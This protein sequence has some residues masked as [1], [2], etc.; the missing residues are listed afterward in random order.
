[1]HKYV[2][3]AIKQPETSHHYWYIVAT[4]ED[5]REHSLGRVIL[6]ERGAKSWLTRWK[7]ILTE[8]GRYF[9]AE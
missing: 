8:E 4:T 6:T 5:G 2:K 7:R 3:L 1:M 9:P